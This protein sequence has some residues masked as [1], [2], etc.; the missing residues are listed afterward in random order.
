M[1]IFQ[2]EQKKYLKIYRDITLMGTG[3]KIYKKILRVQLEEES[4]KNEAVE[5]E[6]TKDGSQIFLI[7][8][9]LKL[10]FDNIKSRRGV[11][12]NKMP[13]ERIEVIEKGEK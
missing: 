10:A 6:I 4:R 8:A 12:K 13:G 9:N 7:L 2:K 5:R 11:W 1:P 3:Y